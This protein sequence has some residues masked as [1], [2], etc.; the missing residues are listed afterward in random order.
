MPDHSREAGACNAPQQQVMPRSGGDAGSM[1]LPM[2]IGGLILVAI[3]AV[4]IMV[5][6]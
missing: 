5:F 4:V 3:G 2:L 6:V 1:L